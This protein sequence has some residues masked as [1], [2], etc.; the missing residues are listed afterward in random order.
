[1]EKPIASGKAPYAAHVV[2][3]EEY[4]RCKCGRGAKQPFRDGTHATLR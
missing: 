4:Y 1:M 3:G 2:A